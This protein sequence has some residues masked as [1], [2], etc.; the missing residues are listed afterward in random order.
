MKGTYLGEFEEIVLLT[1]AVLYNEAYGVVIKK[2]MDEQM[3][4]NISIG[5]IHAALVR[6]EEKGFL[7]SRFGESTQERGGKRKKLYTVTMAG[8]RALKESQDL[9]LKLWNRIPEIA[10]TLK[11]I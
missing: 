11:T 3:D 6:L 2:E 8:Q 1:V 7:E 10:F 4:R 5:A 9:R